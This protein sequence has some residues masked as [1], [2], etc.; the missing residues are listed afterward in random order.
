MLCT[1]TVTPL[2]NKAQSTVHDDSDDDDDDVP[3]CT[4]ITTQQKSEAPRIKLSS[5]LKAGEQTRNER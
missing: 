3:L 2:V 4:N 5:W 1:Y